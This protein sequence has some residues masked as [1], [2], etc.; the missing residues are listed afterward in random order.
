MYKIYA[1]F[2]PGEIDTN[3]L[4]YCLPPERK[5]KLF[6]FRQ[7]I[8]RKN[9]IVAYLLLLHGLYAEYGVFNPILL[10]EQNGKPYLRDYLDIHFNISHCPHGCV[11]AIS[12]SPIGVDIQDIR[13]FSQ[14]IAERCC[15][16]A[17]LGLLKRSTN[18]A[19]E[20]TKMWVMK[21]SYLKMKGT[22][23]TVNLCSIDTTKLTDQIRTFIYN[24]CCIAVACAES[25]R[26][27]SI[28]LN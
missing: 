16:K 4:E 2:D 11:C 25:F 8:D 28:C 18:P 9:C 23:I 15:S 27:E 7:E 1:C 24:S 12:D 6:R 22:G 21:E 26:E 13:P 10:Y 17:E 14:P 5:E 20:F 3:A 19:L